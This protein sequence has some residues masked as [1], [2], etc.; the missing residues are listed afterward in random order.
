MA[1]PGLQRAPTQG[2]GCWV[3][4]AKLLLT[5]MASTHLLVCAQRSFV[6]PTRCLQQ[7]TPLSAATAAAG[8]TAIVGGQ[9]VRVGRPEWVL[10]QLGPTA[11]SASSQLSLT[12]PDH[13][14]RLTSVYVSVG[15][16]LL[17]GLGFRDSLRP[18]A[19]ETVKI[20]QQMGLKILLLS[21]DDTATVKAVAAQAG[22]AVE[23]AYGS[24][25]PSEKLEVIRR[26]Q[27]GCDA[28]VGV[29]CVIPC[30]N[31]HVGVVCVTL[32]QTLT[33]LCCG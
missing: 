4:K 23:N 10:S 16:Q 17:G 29:V 33:S 13:A 24:N 27:V 1:T 22:I 31:A 3:A 25:T 18:D 6:S 19:V 32:C 15:D 21:G 9:Q 26:L 12:T 28:H 11:T 5:E 20:L 8:V 2:I 7:L 14:G 30:Q